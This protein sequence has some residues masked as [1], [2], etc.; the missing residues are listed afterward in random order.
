MNAQ[1]TGLAHGA[2]A[3]LPICVAVAA[4]GVSFGVVAR[5][6]GFGVVAPLIMSLTTFTGASQFAAA[7]VIGDG[8][9]VGAAIVAAILLCTRYGPIG[10][11]VAPVLRGNVF[12]RFVQ[13]QLVIDESWAV[14]NRGGGVIDRGTLIGAG[15]ALYAAWFLGTLA[16]VL[17]GDLIGDPEDFGLDV[18]IPAL[19]L[20]LF[21]PQ[22]QDR[23]PLVAGLVGF[24]IAIVLVPFTPAGVPIVAA[25]L[26]AL[27]GWRR[28]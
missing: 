9:S 3:A 10:L 7:T 15:L 2:R 16:G 28:G 24:T 20:V 12:F 19:F 18:T 21:V 22:V 26:G 27:A 17:G 25:S 6:A 4:F 13:S 23:R 11:S 14:A 5:E 8:G 1:P